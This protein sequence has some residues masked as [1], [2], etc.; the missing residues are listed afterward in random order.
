MEP[1]SMIAATKAI[2]QAAVRLYGF[3]E[4]FKHV[5]DN[6]RALHQELTALAHTALVVEDTLQRPELWAFQDANL[7]TDA[8]EVLRSCQMSLK[9]L[10]D[11]CRG[12]HNSQKRNTAQRVMVQVKLDM[13][14]DAIRRMRE[15]LG[16][17]RLALQTI[18][19]MINIYISAKA[20]QVVLDV[21]QPQLETLTNMISQLSKAQ[22][23]MEKEALDDRPSSIVA[24][25]KRV[26]Y[27]AQSVVDAMSIVGDARY[28]YP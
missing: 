10:E 26:L 8:D 24:T 15:Q 18:T 1:L 22:E 28:V 23:R 7:W 11:S 12:L 13:K 27:S 6:T 3:I 5:D 2:G 20:P 14:D 17:H 4:G 21:V 19:G 25:N 9:R 16:S